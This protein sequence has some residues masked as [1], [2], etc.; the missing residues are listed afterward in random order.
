VETAETLTHLVK[1][2]IVWPKPTLYSL[3]CH[4][5]LRLSSF[6]LLNGTDKHNTP[7]YLHCIITALLPLSPTRLDTRTVCNSIVN[8]Y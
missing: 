4:A 6:F 5:W 2:I 1:T 3:L 7:F 8:I